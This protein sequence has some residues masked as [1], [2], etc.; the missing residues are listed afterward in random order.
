VPIVHITA[1]NVAGLSFNRYQSL[2]VDPVG[3]IFNNSLVSGTSVL[4]RIS[5]RIGRG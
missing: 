1:P 5:K 3:L 4:D 2:D